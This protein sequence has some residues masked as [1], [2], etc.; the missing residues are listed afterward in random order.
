[1]ILNF[2]KK[3]YFKHLSHLQCNARLVTKYSVIVNK[4]FLNLF[5]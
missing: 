5:L 3:Q 1:M 2:I 4:L